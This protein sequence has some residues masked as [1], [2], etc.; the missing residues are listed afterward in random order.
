MI[1]CTVRL[2][3]SLCICALEF[4]TS[5]CIYIRVERRE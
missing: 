1:D 4:Q 3:A 2:L 5:Q